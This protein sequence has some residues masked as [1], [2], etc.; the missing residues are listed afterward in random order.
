MQWTNKIWFY[1]RLLEFWTVWNENANW[2]AILTNCF[3]WCL[4]SILKKP[5]LMLII[6][7]NPLRFVTFLVYLTL[8]RN[9]FPKLSASR[10][11]YFLVTLVTREQKSRNFRVSIKG[12]IRACVGWRS[13]S[14]RLPLNIPNSKM[15]V[16]EATEEIR[17]SRVVIQGISRKYRLF[18][19]RSIRG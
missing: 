5:Y 15:I 12:G 10:F 3:G 9:S 18:L 13:L 8:H 16:R 2:R 14:S 11:T 7:E 17:H 4:V 6:S 1:L 19:K